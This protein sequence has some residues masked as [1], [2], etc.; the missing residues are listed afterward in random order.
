MDSKKL[1]IKCDADKTFDENSCVPFDSL[2][3]SLCVKA[4]KDLLEHSVVTRGEIEEFT[5][6]IQ[7]KDNQLMDERDKISDLEIK[8]SI[9]SQRILE[10][11]DL[12]ASLRKTID[13][14]VTE[15]ETYFNRISTHEA[16]IK[17][18]DDQIIML[19]KNAELDKLKVKDEAILFDEKIKTKE[20]LIEALKQS[21]D[22]SK[23]NNV[24]SDN[25]ILSMR[26]KIDKLIE[27]KATFNEDQLKTENEISQLKSDVMSKEKRLKE[28]IALINDIQSQLVAQEFTIKKLEQINAS[29]H[30][31]V[32]EKD[33][34]LE[35]KN[36]RLEQWEN[37]IFISIQNGSTNKL[38]HVPG[39]EPFEPVMADTTI[40]GPGWIVIQSRF[41]QS[42]DFVRDFADY[43]K[44]FGDTKGEFWLGLE[45]IHKITTHEQHQL[46][47]NIINHNNQIY[48]SRYD[49]FVVGS[50]EEG[51][52][53]KSLGKYNGNIDNMRIC[54]EK[55]FSIGTVSK[56][57]WWFSKDEMLS[58]NLN[59]KLFEKEGDVTTYTLMKSVQMLIMP[60]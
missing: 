9:Y 5:R 17:N 16:T 6:I 39:L 24:L 22:L 45:R 59:S 11:N 28:N 2:C 57:G 13:K 46:F 48:W 20:E 60:R 19:L 37:K 12:I 47:I 31:Q 42:V 4:V 38:M 54:L 14:L 3:G 33:D 25:L 29:L 18:K 21:V 36:R 7:E 50:K 26:A 27:Q 53:L 30:N 23:G 58:N 41:N 52:Q 56:S 51:Y 40:A 8:L 35:N 44:G 43:Q 55:H 32:M 15:Q 49:N 34:Q 1:N 10:R